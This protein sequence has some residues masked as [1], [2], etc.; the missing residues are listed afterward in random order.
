MDLLW[1]SSQ[2][3][4]EFDRGNLEY[5]FKKIRQL[6][7]RRTTGYYSVMFAEFYRKDRNMLKRIGR[8]QEYS[9][10]SVVSDDKE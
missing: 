4:N 7:A 8:V 5:I 1:I 6:G 10:A 2:F 9:D 3:I